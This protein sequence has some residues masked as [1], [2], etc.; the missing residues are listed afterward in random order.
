MPHGGQALFEV[1]K[2]AELTAS[3]ELAVKDRFYEVLLAGA[4]AR[5]LHRF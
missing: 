1:E 5:L 2:A 4:G 3:A